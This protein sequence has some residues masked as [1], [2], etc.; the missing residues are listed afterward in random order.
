MFKKKKSCDGPGLAC[1]L[2][3]I[4]QNKDQLKVYTGPFIMSYY[5]VPSQTFFAGANKCP[6]QWQVSCLVSDDS[7]TLPLDLVINIAP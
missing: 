6:P 2:Y 4:L 5:G 3:L 7:V 1:W